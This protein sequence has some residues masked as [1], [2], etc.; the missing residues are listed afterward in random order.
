MPGICNH[1]GKDHE[2]VRVRGEYFRY[3]SAACDKAHTAQRLKESRTRKYGS[4]IWICSA[5]AEERPWQGHENSFLKEALLQC[6]KCD[7]VTVHKK[8]AETE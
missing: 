5:C 2:R 4:V 6:E 7:A 1:C 3:C 8:E